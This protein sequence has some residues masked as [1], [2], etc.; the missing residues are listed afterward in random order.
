MPGVGAQRFPAFAPAVGATAGAAGDATG[1][2]AGEATGA[3]APY[4]VLDVGSNSIRLVVFEGLTR[5][6]APCFN[7]RELCGLGASLAETGTLAP[8]AVAPALDALRRFAAAAAALGTGT[9][10]AVATAAVRDASDGEGFRAAVARETGFALRVLSGQEE[11]RY[12]ALGVVSAFPAASGLMADLGGGSLELVRLDRGRLAEHATLPL[13]V[14]RLG[15]LAPGRRT[16]LAAENLR[17]LPWLDSVQGAPVYL[18]GG[19]WRALARLHMADRQHPI[20]V[21]HHYRLAA[22]EA[23]EA[24]RTFAAA[25]PRTL[26]PGPEGMWP[27][28]LATVPSGAAVLRAL[29]K[30]A[31]PSEVLFS[32]FGLREGLLFDRL[33][34]AVR[35]LDPLQDACRAIAARDGRSLAYAEALGAWLARAALP[36]LGPHRDLC[37]AAAFLSEIAWRQHPDLRAA[38]AFTRISRAPF[39]GIDHPGRVFLALAVATRYKSSL[40]AEAGEAANRLLPDEAQAAARALGLALRL[41]ER[42][43]CGEP[44]VLDASHMAAENGRLTLRLAPAHRP[45]A[46]GKASAAAETLARALD[47]ML[48]LEPGG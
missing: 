17:A 32:A 44:A 31:A 38:D 20:A 18:V 8:E 14:L 12:A 15:N 13:G 16:A 42:L 36:A 29:L 35:A 21:V 9:L 23:R 22:A 24:A 19:A 3:D 4:G 25:D 28:R 39:V 1:E 26:R 30:A 2:A 10:D 6:P 47:C 5:A 27:Q 48:C 7:E 46:S 34:A 37:P 33:P 43:S 41:A 45:L 40:P 11:A